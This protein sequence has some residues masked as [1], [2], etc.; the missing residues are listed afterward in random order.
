MG[1]EQ[2]TIGNVYVRTGSTMIYGDTGIDWSGGNVQMGYRF[3]LDTDGAPTYNIATVLTATQLQISVSYVEASKASHP[4]LIT[5][6]FSSN[7]GY[8]RPWQGDTDFADIC[9]ELIVDLIDQDIGRILGGTASIQGTSATR[10]HAATLDTNQITATNVEAGVGHVATLTTNNLTATTSH[11][12]IGHVAT[13]TS[14]NL[15]A[16]TGTISNLT[17]TKAYLGAYRTKVVS[18][19]ADY[20]ATSTDAM[21]IISGNTA[22]VTVVLP[23]TVA[24]NKGMILRILNNSAS[25]VV[26][27]CNDTGDSIDGANSIRLASQYDTT[28]LFL[29]TPTLWTEL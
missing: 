13:L 11:T 17:V 25:P 7:R 27:T 8:A 12:D 23:S 20:S 3:K 29:A 24:A 26:A 4:Y 2:Y 28:E 19:A 14:N 1:V 9:R 16:T 22:S 6:S 10:F 21:I 18:K 15:T 5:R